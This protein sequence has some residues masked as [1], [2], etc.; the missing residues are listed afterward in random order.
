MEKKCYITSSSILDILKF[1]IPNLQRSLNQE[2]VQN[3]L[4][5]QIKEY[6]KHGCFSLLQSITVAKLDD[7]F[8]ILDGCHRRYVY[9]LLQTQGYPIDN[10]IIP[11]VIYKVDTSNEL[12]EYYAKI[13]KNM[14]IHPLEVTT[15]W[16]DCEK[17]LIEF[18]NQNYSAYLK[19]TVICKS[20]HISLTALKSNLLVRELSSSIITQLCQ[21]ILEVNTYISQNTKTQLCPQISKRIADCE[22]KATKHNMSVCYLGIFRHFEWLDIALY[23]LKNDIGNINIANFIQT[24]QKIPS[25]V[26]IQ[27]WKN[28]YNNTMTGKCYTC[29][30][31]LSYIDME[32]GHIIAR[33]LNGPDTINNLVPICKTCNK[34]MGVMNLYE[35]KKLNALYNTVYMSE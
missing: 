5:D 28:H 18:L 33:A 23:L 3:I 10:V 29:E 20:P 6:K 31:E 22:S 24:K 11:M 14:P 19:N 7:K 15:N 13:N 16:A 4:E 32:C 30:R 27:L 21:K 8:Y 12:L 9:E 26:R 34:D 2:H 25:D 17:I 1:T 35:Y